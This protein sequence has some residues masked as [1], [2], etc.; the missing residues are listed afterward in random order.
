MPCPPLWHRRCLCF[1]CPY[2][3]AF[4]RAPEKPL[5]PFHILPIDGEQLGT[6]AM[7]QHNQHILRVIPQGNLPTAWP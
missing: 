4:A 5:P 3:D 6:R 7:L 2:C 1:H